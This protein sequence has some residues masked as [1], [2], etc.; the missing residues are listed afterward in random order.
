[1]TR[2]HR[3]LLDAA[4]RAAG[5]ADPVAFEP[6]E[7]RDPLVKLARRGP[8]LPLDGV[9]VRDWDPDARR[10]WVG[11]SFGARCYEVGGVKFCRVY[12]PS[13]TELT[14][15]AYSFCVVARGD[16]ARLYKLAVAARR[17]T[18]PPAM[19]PVVADETLA[20]LRRNT[21]D[22]LE[23]ANLGRI[24]DLGGRPRR[25]LLLSGPPG[26][27]K[28]SACRWLRRLCTERGLEEKVVSPDDYRTARSGPCAS[29]SVRELFALD[30]PGV[31]FFDDFDAALSDRAASHG[32]DDQAVF[33]GALDGMEVNSGVAHVFTTNLPINRIDPAFRR[34]GR[35]DVVLQF[36]KPDAN[37]RRKLVTRWH[38][39]LLAGIDAEL[40]V[41]DT[42][43][44]S[45]A[46]VDE[47]KNL[48]VLRFTEAG[49]WDW[50]WAREQFR[51]GRG[52]FT[53]GPARVGF[54][55][56]RNGAG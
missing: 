35:L 39:E 10:T 30:R 20:A 1:M 29:E 15:C 49:E 4:G 26:N 14:S 48:L 36:P 41:R 7:F 53:A 47:L 38:A 12:A 17:A 19:P 18:A 8:V 6:D 37:L 22:Y 34:P 23:S 21:V 31:V 43:G 52:D 25:G 32:G 45:F 24:R 54:G 2:D 33:L 28:T 16:Y 27:G 9:L 3:W 56:V 50:A 51:L 40:A 42:E 55:A 11:T 13:D 46:E 5:I 44:M